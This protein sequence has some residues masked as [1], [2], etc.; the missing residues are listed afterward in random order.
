[1]SKY[2]PLSD[3]LSRHEA[4]LWTASFAELEDVLGF[5]LPKSAREQNAWWRG[6]DKSHHSAWTEP[7]WRV[8]DID[9]TAQTVVFQRDQDMAAPASATTPQA[10]PEAK[11]DPEVKAAK[12]AGLVMPTAVVGGAAALLA[13]GVAVLAGFLARRKG[14]PWR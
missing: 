13:G 6:G 12:R 3:R 1:M 8:M 11:I 5:P 10:A 14:E 4:D 9:R 2:K 7:G